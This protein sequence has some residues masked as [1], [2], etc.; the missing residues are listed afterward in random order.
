MQI[1]PFNH[2]HAFHHALEYSG[3]TQHS[4]V[5]L[6]TNFKLQTI[7]EGNGKYLSVSVGD[8]QVSTNRP[9]EGISY[10]SQSERGW[11][12]VSVEVVVIVHNQHVSL[13]RNAPTTT[14]QGITVGS[15]YGWSIGAGG[16]AMG[17]APMATVNAGFSSSTS[18]SKT[19]SEF[20]VVNTSGA[21]ELFHTY[22]LCTRAHGEY[23]GPSSLVVHRHPSNKLSKYIF[24]G[25]ND[26]A[27][28][29]FPLVSQGI[30]HTDDDNFSEK[31]P[32]H[33]CV[34]PTFELV[35]GIKHFR[36]GKKVFNKH[37]VVW[38]ADAMYEVNFGASDAETDFIHLLKQDVEEGEG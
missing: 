29:D 15:N 26:G 31:V 1:G 35:N 2:T 17:D 27:K 20:K 11:Y 33:V 32:V 36:F 24:D 23:T 3:K 8:T 28:S 30:W 14:E 6:I 38:S 5:N 19:L 4:G 16:G 12:I 18:T 7:P 21:K 25:L 10:D 22:K 34:S 13:V 9:G 37:T